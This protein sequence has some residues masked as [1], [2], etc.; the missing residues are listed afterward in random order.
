MSTS[1]QGS[2]FKL[3]ARADYPALTEHSANDIYPHS[4]TFDP[5][6]ARYVK[7]KWFT[8]RSMPHWHPGKGHPA[9]VFVDE[10]IVK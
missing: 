3:A 8:L 1:T 9:F 2:D 5:I 7:V 4:L 6:K 10:V